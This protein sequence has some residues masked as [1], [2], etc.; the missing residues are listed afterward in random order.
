MQNLKIGL[1]VDGIN[2][3]KSVRDLIKWSQTSPNIEISHLIIQEI[4]RPHRSLLGRVV[5]RIRKSGISSL[6]GRSVME[7]VIRL[8]R[9]PMLLR[10]CA[11]DFLKLHDVSADVSKQVIVHPQISKSGFVFRYC[12]D[13]L[14]R[15]RDEKFDLLIRCGSG[16]LRGE[17]LGVSRL[18]VISFHHGD[19]RI[20][21]GG[22]AGF[23]EVL[24]QEDQTGFIIQKLTEDLDAGEVLMRGGFPTQHFYSLNQMSIIEQ[25][26]P[27]MFELLRR[28]ADVGA[29]PPT[30]ETNK[31]LGP[32]LKSPDFI[33]ATFYLYKLLNLY[34]ERIFNK[35]RKIN[36]Q[37]VVRIL[38]GHPLDSAS[39]IMLTLPVDKNCYL[40]DPFLI[41]KNGRTFCFVEEYVY[42]TKQGKIVAYEINGATVGERMVC[43]DE[44]FHLSFPFIFEFKENLYMCPET[45]ASND[46]RIY[47]CIEFPNSWTLETI[48]IPN[49]SAAD[50]MIFE[51]DERWWMMTNIDRSGLG[52]HSSE[53]SI[54]YADSPISQTWKPHAMNPIIINSKT[55]R[56]GGLVRTNGR[57]YRA[58]QEQGF[59]LYGKSVTLHE[60]VE[61]SIDNYRE[62][63]V[64][65]IKPD[66]M[67]GEI[68]SHHISTGPNIWARD[69]LKMVS[70]LTS[71]REVFNQR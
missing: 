27:Y 6:L 31:V 61:L 13:D 53:L 26:N 34:S 64:R 21:R 65:V 58:G 52:D 54:F 16:I 5:M 49:I 71:T 45:V 3:S 59:D 28:V 36:P 33:Q 30:I 17:I 23:W 2:V 29:L 9:K 44:P 22:P 62:L 69:A 25:S 57:I 20:Y 19:N 56:N 37:W 24:N 7:I 55:A 43:L 38:E 11:V 48:L 66:L 1:I 68:G 14:A 42:Q 35:L 10:S 15:I 8:E 51:K 60:I 12:K 32:I 70:L 40:A 18:G 63:A 67:S 4:P 39:K 46:I 41:S 47:R 50:T